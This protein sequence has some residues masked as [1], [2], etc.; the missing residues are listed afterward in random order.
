MHTPPP[1]FAP[2]EVRFADGAS[3][4]VIWTGSPGLTCLPHR[5][6]IAW[7]LVPELDDLEIAA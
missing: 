4:L 6:A 1:A 3:A 5:N 7:R 2:V